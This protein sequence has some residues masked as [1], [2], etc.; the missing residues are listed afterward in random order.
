M[1][2]KNLPNVSKQFTTTSK[3]ANNNIYIHVGNAISNVQDAKK[4]LLNVCKFVV[5]NSERVGEVVNRNGGAVTETGVE[6]VSKTP[7]GTV[8][9]ETFK[10]HF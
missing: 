7:E 6:S 9:I 8:E 3:T 5:I 2:F 4:F 1:M 10:N